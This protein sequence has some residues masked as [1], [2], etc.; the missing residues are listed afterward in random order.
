MTHLP[1]AGMLTLRYNL[2]NEFFK[3]AIYFLNGMSYNEGHITVSEKQNH[4]SRVLISTLT[5]STKVK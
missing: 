2:I 1:I 3:L 4:K 5:A